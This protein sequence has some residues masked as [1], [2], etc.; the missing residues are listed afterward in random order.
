MSEDHGESGVVH[1]TQHQQGDEDQAG[2]HG[3]REQSAVS[4]RLWTRPLR[5]DTGTGSVRR[6]RWT[7]PLEEGHGA[8]SHQV[9]S[10]EDDEAAD[11]GE[12]SVCGTGR[13]LEA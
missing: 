4:G 2:Q 9:Q 3:G 6:R 11:A 5:S 7:H 13:R 8:A 10:V 12:D 1:I